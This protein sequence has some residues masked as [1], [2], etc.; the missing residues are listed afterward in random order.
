MSETIFEDK[1]FRFIDTHSK[2]SELAPLR[3]ILP[4]QQVR[5]FPG[6]AEPTGVAMTTSA[7]W[8]CHF[9]YFCVTSN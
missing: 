7:L 8:K 6:P 3:Q 1:H 2:I 9:V 5:Y 4:C